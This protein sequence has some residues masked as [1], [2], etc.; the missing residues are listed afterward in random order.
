MDSLEFD[1]LDPTKVWSEYL[2][3]LIEVGTMT[4]N[5]NPQ[6]FFAELEQAAFTPSATVPG[7]EPFE[8]KLL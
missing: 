3:P 1:P 4:L 5:R 8:N 2:F 6:N 7:I